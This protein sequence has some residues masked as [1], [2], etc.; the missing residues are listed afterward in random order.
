[1]TR[2]SKHHL[3]KAGAPRDIV[4][5]VFNPDDGGSKR[6][7]N[8]GQFLPDYT[9]QHPTRHP[10]FMFKKQIATLRRDDMC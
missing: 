7:R 4:V 10:S 5:A 6:F 8:V 3:W 1:M 2:S 9:A